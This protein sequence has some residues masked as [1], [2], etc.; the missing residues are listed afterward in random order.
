MNKSFFIT[1]QSGCLLPVLIFFNLFFG[2]LFFKPLS[3]AAIEAALILLFIL[4]LYFFTKS[5]SSSS[6]IKKSNVIDTEGEV[7]EDK[8]SLK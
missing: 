5:I 6:I 2:R 7:V 1:A 8:K 4:N 3:W